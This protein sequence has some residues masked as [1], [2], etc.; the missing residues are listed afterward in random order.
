MSQIVDDLRQVA[1]EI[2]TETQVGGNTAARVGGAFE[3]VA[4]ALEGTQQ[5][6]DMDAAVAAVQAQ[7]QQ[8]E[9]TIQDLVNNL[10]VTQTTGQSTSSV[11]SQKAVTDR[12]I[13]Q[14]DVT[15]LSSG[16]YNGLA[17]ST[18]RV[19]ASFTSSIH[20]TSSWKCQK[21]PCVEG[22]VFIIT[23][24]GSSAIYCYALVGSDGLVK[25]VGTQNA[26]NTRITTN[27]NEAYLY[28][29][30]QTSG[31][32]SVIKEIG[33]KEMLNEK[34]NALSSR[35][36]ANKEEIKLLKYDKNPNFLKVYESTIDGGHEFFISNGSVF[37]VKFETY[38]E[39]AKSSNF[40]IYK[41]GAAIYTK[42]KI[43][44]QCPRYCYLDG[45]I[46]YFASVMMASLLDGG[47]STQDTI[48]IFTLDLT[49]YEWA[50][51][52][53]TLTRNMVYR[54]RYHYTYVNFCKFNNTLYAV[55][56]NMQAG[57]GVASVVTLYAITNDITIVSNIATGK[58]HWGKGT[59]ANI[60]LDYDTP[61]FATL[62]T[63]GT[64]MY[65]RYIC[66]LGLVLVKKS[67]DLLNWEKY[68]ILGATQFRQIGTDGDNFFP[69]ST[70]LFY[71]QWD[72]GD[73][74]FC[75]DEKNAYKYLN[76]SSLIKYLGEASSVSDRNA[77]VIGDYL[78]IYGRYVSN[79]VTKSGIW[80]CNKNEIYWMMCGKTIA[81]IY[82]NDISNVPFGYSAIVTK[83]GE[84]GLYQ[85]N[86]GIAVSATGV[87]AASKMLSIPYRGINK[88]INLGTSK[89]HTMLPVSDGC[90]TW[91][92]TFLHYYP[93]YNEFQSLYFRSPDVC[94]SVGGNI[95]HALGAARYIG[96]GDAVIM[97]PIYGRSLD[98][99]RTWQDKRV[100][101]H[102]PTG[103]SYITKV[104]IAGGLFITDT[105]ENSPHYGRIYVLSEIINSTNNSD[106]IADLQ[107]VMM[108]TDDNGL[109]WH[110]AWDNSDADGSYI[111]I[112]SQIVPDNW[113]ELGWKRLNMSDNLG[114]T[115]VGGAYDGMLYFSLWIDYG[116]SDKR[117][118]IVYSTDNGQTWTLGATASTGNESAI[119]QKDDHTLLMNTRPNS[120][121]AT[122]RLFYQMDLSAG[123]ENATWERVSGTNSP[124]QVT[125]E[126][127]AKINDVYLL[128]RPIST[129]S[130]GY[131]KSQITL[132]KSRD[133]VNWEKIITLT[134]K[135]TRSTNEW[136]VAISYSNIIVDKHHL[137]VLLET[138]DG[139]I[140]YH[141]L[142]C[143]LPYVLS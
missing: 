15:N 139:S 42:S 125:Q 84:T 67:N 71:G 21:V 113:S 37:F 111:D 14:A 122:K 86:T 1:I 54:M 2:K 19:G 57:R 18:C 13:S 95:I 140:E 7:A 11:M 68:E 107:V 141:N 9:Q 4:D 65:C 20:S 31:T 115:F 30:G 98:G 143:L 82:T 76:V 130:L 22:D 78:Y 92:S 77:K 137:G 62:S 53:S 36:D 33:I 99:G 28:I 94:L 136:V 47:T 63:D 124:T 58:E 51:L 87:G 56:S 138:K 43:E 118:T 60:L 17:K 61:A 66:E 74:G 89:G 142:D 44:G 32:I 79:G 8:S 72:N 108:H 45:N 59:S 103:G 97:E 29:S 132:F 134:P 104:R 50:Q 135:G 112:T 85:Y 6:E 96:L 114:K 102:R 40:T 34:E 90:A 25:R 105:N 12:I 126:G 70:P 119:V 69:L 133:L 106:F 73:Y 49:T 91:Q 16:Y 120:V 93:F 52:G 101:I 117:P 109:T 38:N 24:T 39:N 10:A 83:D 55:M 26:S 116:N 23:A 35:I 64:N 80:R 75:T 27:A 128:T 81:D 100:L 129:D 110:G 46:M 131:L 41:D 48:K 121:S 5:I 3:R 88:I 127:W 123:I